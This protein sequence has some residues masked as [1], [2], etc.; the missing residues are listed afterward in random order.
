MNAMIMAV[1]ILLPILGGALVP[2][3][4][5][6][7]RIWMEFYVEGLV[8]LNSILVILMLPLYSLNLPEI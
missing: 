1:V 7:K 4:P 6:K 2:L 5:L 8:V 3:L